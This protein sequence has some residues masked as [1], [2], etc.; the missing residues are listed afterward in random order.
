MDLVLAKSLNKKA[1]QLFK[2]QNNLEGLVCIAPST[3]PP[4][5]RKKIRSKNQSYY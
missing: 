1:K 2:T 5:G 4:F 3:K